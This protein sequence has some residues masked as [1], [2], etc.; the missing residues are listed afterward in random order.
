MTI[1]FF[2]FCLCVHM[3]QP[4][5]GPVSEEEVK[6]FNHRAQTSEFSLHLCKQ[7]K[8]FRHASTCD[9]KLLHLDKD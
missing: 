9:I 4:D 1:F 6:D 8:Y 7:D 2:F 5:S 3:L